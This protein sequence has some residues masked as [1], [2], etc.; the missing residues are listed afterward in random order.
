ME[1]SSQKKTLSKKLIETQNSSGFT[2]LFSVLVA[3]LVLAVG[4]SVI[5]IALRQLIISSTGRDSQYAFYAANTG[6]ECAMYWDLKRGSNFATSSQSAKFSG[7]MICENV[8]VADALINSTNLDFFNVVGQTKGA[9]TRFRLEFNP[10]GPDS[11]IIPYCVD[12]IVEKKE[13]ITPI[14]PGISRTQM[15]TEIIAR[16]YNTCEEN[17]PRR[18]ERGLEVKY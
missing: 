1:N 7:P 17:N 9:V 12:V 16:G 6:I 13:E 5:S 10:V 18:I 14:Q 3:S 15:R 11:V 2:L 8:D 4:A